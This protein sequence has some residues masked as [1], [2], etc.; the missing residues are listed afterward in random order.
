MKG[1]WR[2]S[3]NGVVAIL[4][5]LSVVSGCSSGGGGTGDAGGTP[6]A[7]KPSSETKGETKGPVTLTVWAGSWWQDIVPKVVEAYEKEH[8]N[9]KLKMELLPING[10]LDK[11]TA[12]AL[13]GN[14]P[15]LLELDSTMISSMAGKGLIDTWDEYIQGLDVKDFAPGM[16]NASKFK[17][18][19]YALPHRGGSQVYYYNK[20]MFDE[21]GVPYPTENWT[22][23]DMLEIAKKITVPG[24]KYG[25]GLAASNSD[26]ANV[27]TSFAPM[28]WAFGGDFLN[29][30]STE[31]IINRPEAVK[32]IQFWAELYTKYKVAPEGTINYSLTKDVLPMFINNQVAMMPGTSNTFDELKKHP[33]LK[34]GMQLGP[35]KFGRGGGWA[36]SVPKDAKQKQEARDFVLWFVKPENLGKL[37]NREPSRASATNVPPWNSEEFKIIFK[38]AP[39]QKM[40]PSV[41]SWTEMQTVII[42]ELQKV[43][44]GNKTPQQAAD[45]MAK[46]MNALLKK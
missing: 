27:F 20:T 2:L 32:G 9:V 46:Q 22:H 1:Q 3:R 4:I 42:T 6:T 31:A 19:L 30:D 35:D 40:L 13:G 29:A 18:K 45:D 28:V 44:Q 37:A 10:Y 25:I 36:F 38:A 26:Q 43:L 12:A 41:G 7:A 34:W 5:T 23:Q 16:W 17:G 14:P 8:P 21:A 11:A 39:F 33:E 15:D 24:K